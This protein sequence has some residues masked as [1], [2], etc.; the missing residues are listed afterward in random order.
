MNEEINKII[1][2]LSKGEIAILPTDTV[3][4]F[5]GIVDLP[6]NLAF[7]TDDKI[8]KIKGR[9]EKKPL[10]QLISKPEE[11]YL[12]TDIKIPEKSLKFFI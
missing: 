8:R 11:V 1:D 3:Y 12:F 7:N 2:V 4:G 6:G 5:S 9:D 10:I